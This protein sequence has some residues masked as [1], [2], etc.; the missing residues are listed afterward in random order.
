MRS[1]PAVSLAPSPPGWAGLAVATDPRTALA[2]PG[3]RPFFP[4]TVW[5]EAPE[6][7]TAWVFAEDAPAAAPPRI[8]RV[9]PGPWPWARFG[10]RI[11]R[12]A[13]L[14]AE[15]AMPGLVREGTRGSGLVAA[16][17]AATF[18]AA[19]RE[20]RVAGPA[21]LPDPGAAGLGVA[22]GDAVLVLDR[23]EAGC[24]RAVRAMWDSAR[25][26]AAGRPVIA[27]RIGTGQATLPGAIGPFAAWTLI[28]AAAEWHG[29]EDDGL[30]RIAAAAGVSVYAQAARPAFGDPHDTPLERFARLLAA[31]R[32]ADPFRQVPCSAEEALTIMASWQ[33]AASENRRI[34]V[35]CGMASW[36]RA[37]LGAA[38]ASE[39]GP[40]AFR[41]S[42]RGAVAEASR[43]GGAIAVWATREPPG[44]RKAAAA[45]GVAVLR[46]EDG[47]LRSAGLGAGFLPGGSIAL[48]ARGVAYDPAIASDLEVILAET[49]FPPAMLARAAR[50]RAALLGRGITK[51]NLPG[52]D[53]PPDV[54]AGRR[55]VLV[56]GQVEDDASV[57]LGAMAGPRKNLD[58][59]RAAREAEPE[60]F[61]LYRPHP[62]VAAGYRAGHVLPAD[63]LAFADVVQEG[64]AMPDLLDWTDTV[65]TITSLTGFEALLR[66]KRVVCQGMPFYAGWGL[67]EDRQALPRRTRRLSLD[68]LVAGALIAY[69]RCM[70][71]VT[72]L[73]CPPEVLVDRLTQPAAWR[74]GRAAL[75]RRMQGRLMAGLA[76]RGWLR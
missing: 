27:V 8:I 76:R 32:F 19:M 46:V 48:D 23:C 28:E 12:A 65:H 45:A 1:S 35:A 18:L 50:L 66:G 11:G 9:G 57:R 53:A 6:A 61:I 30:A 68:A 52:A 73:P 3:L 26:V 16:P 29:L 40:P 39:A 21:G 14:A 25:A 70:D 75:L 20:A 72:E 24:A 74:A 47:F 43:R 59:L 64:A 44:L 51:Y 13:L 41:R 67:T 60:A 63:A 34:A 58:L 10:A 62:D 5:S 38:L 54:A 31:T 69:P 17:E 49:A 15:Q 55:R 42:T 4:E 71:P 37:R 56:P 7:A 36:K 22:P 2:M 33:R